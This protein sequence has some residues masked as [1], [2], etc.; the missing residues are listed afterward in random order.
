M[1]LLSLLASLILALGACGPAAGGSCD[2]DRF[3]CASGE[4]ALECRDSKWREVP[5]RGANGCVEGNG[6]VQCDVSSG[7]RVNDPCA[8]PHE[9]TSVCSASLDALLECRGGVWLQTQA[10]A[11]TCATTSTGISCQ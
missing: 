11:T 10:C 6:Q 5:C 7:M 1:R 2:S 4:A 8:D 9:G 3:A